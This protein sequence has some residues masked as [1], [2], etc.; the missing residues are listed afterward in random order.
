MSVFLLGSLYFSSAWFFALWLWYVSMCVFLWVYLVATSVLL[1]QDMSS[2]PSTLPSWNN[3]SWPTFCGLWFQYLFCLQ[4]FCSVIQIY[5][6]WV[7]PR[8][9]LG[10]WVVNYPQ[11]SV[12]KVVGWLLE[13]EPHM[14]SLETGRIFHPQQSHGIPSS[15][16]LLPTVVTLSART[17][18]PALWLETQGFHLSNVLCTSHSRVTSRAKSFENKQRK[19]SGE[20]PHFSDNSYV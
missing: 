19:G 11:S 13:L 20:Y 8:G 9:E 18:F 1:P 14:C 16:F 6:V 7:S 12:L 4:T 5:S 10:T 3:L 2:H 17:S 15:I